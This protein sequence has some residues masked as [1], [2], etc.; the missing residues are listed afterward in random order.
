MDCPADVLKSDDNPAPVEG[1]RYGGSESDGPGVGRW[2][3][4]GGSGTPDYAR[5]YRFPSLGEVARLVFALAVMWL[6][7]IVIQ[8]PANSAVSAVPHVDPGPPL[9]VDASQRPPST[10]TTTSGSTTPFIS[11]DR[12]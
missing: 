7:V 4:Y 11:E 3:P 1:T 5:T 10:A 9:Y 12:Q 6:S 8:I 2:V